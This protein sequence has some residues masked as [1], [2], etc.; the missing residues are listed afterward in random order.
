MLATWRQP[1]ALGLV[2]EFALLTGIRCWDLVTNRYYLR[3]G[4]LAVFGCGLSSWFPERASEFVEREHLPS[5]IFNSYSLGGY[6]TWRLPANPD[7]IDGRAVPFGAEMFFRAYNLTVQPPDSALWKQEAEQID[8]NTV[9]VSL[10][11][12]TSVSAFPPLHLFCKSPDWAPVFLDPVSAVF[13]RRTAATAVLA[14]RLQLDCDKVSFNPPPALEASPL[15]RTRAELFRLFV[16]AAGVLHALGRDTEAIAFTDRALTIFTENANLHLIRALALQDVGRNQEAE[17]EFL[18]S[19]RLAPTDEAWFDLGLLYMTQQRY[20]DAADLFRHSAQASSRA[21]DMWM[22][23]GQAQLFL[24][25]PQEALDDFDKAEAASPFGPQGEELGAR[26]ES[27]IATGR[28]KAWYQL[29][30]LAKSVAFQEQAVKAAPDDAK[31]WLGLADLYDAEGRAAEAQQA[32][33]RA[34]Q[35]GK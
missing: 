29:G 19:L 7:Y 32:R 1:V 4:E 13:L 5:N 8:I 21:H 11:A 30:D 33:R 17:Q 14:D 2:M 10:A 12:T 16:N 20:A 34:Q 3:S 35:L 25:K 15:N 23:L 18:A 9:I 28:A 22:M 6:L 24:G 31:L 27:L 26:F